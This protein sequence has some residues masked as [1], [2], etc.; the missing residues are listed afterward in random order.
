[1][2]IAPVSG[3]TT[4]SSIPLNSALL[5]DED[6]SF[7]CQPVPLGQKVQ[8]KVLRRQ[9]VS[10]SVY[11]LYELYLEGGTGSRFFLLSARRKKGTRGATYAI[12]LARHD[13]GKFE[14]NVI[15]KVRCDS[16]VGMLIMQIELFRNSIYH[17]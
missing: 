10:G 1:M 9:N 3:L 11:P 13:S 5:S 2:P 15:A 14:E 12:S 6:E 4:P 8:C 16:S 17:L 7:I